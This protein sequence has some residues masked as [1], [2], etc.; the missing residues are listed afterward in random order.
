MELEVRL[1]AERRPAGVA[2]DSVS[3][4]EDMTHS[5]RMLA[6][7]EEAGLFSLQNEIVFLLEFH[8]LSAEDWSTFLARPKAGSLEADED[9]LGRVLSSVP[10]ENDARFV[11]A[12]ADRQASRR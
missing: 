9:L 1:G 11:P 7:M 2:L 3:A 12:D 8:F 5:H 4:L 10:G 6:E